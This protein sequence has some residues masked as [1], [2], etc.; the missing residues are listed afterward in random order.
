M[1]TKL[2]IALFV[3]CG[4]AA[5]AVA[6][7]I[8]LYVAARHVPQ[9]YSEAMAA[10]EAVQ[11][12]AAERMDRQAMEL[13]SD[14]QKSGHWQMTIT[15]A[16]INAWLA[17][18]MPQKLPHAL[19]PSMQNPRVAIEPNG[20][21]LGCQYQQGGVTS[22]LTL[23]VEPYVPEPGV[24]ALRIRKARAGLLPMP[25]QQVLDG[26][27]KALQGSELRTQWRQADGDP[28]LRIS[29]SPEQSKRVS[30]ETLQLRKG[31]L[32]VEGTTEKR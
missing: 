31:E 14:S 28:V 22:V 1:G 11:R 24:L 16:D 9:F 18:A 12:P 23:T 19:P 6:V 5:L 32:Y 26:I 3:A 2:R 20:I 10:D 7:L 4:L 13:A 15:A 27:K 8:V 29:S 21:T 17:V 30:I 25:L